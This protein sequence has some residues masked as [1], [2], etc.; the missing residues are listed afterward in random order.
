M[1]FAFITHHK[2]TARQI[3]LAAEKDIELVPVGVT[4]NFTLDAEM[5]DQLGGFDGV[6][7]HHPA[8]ALRLSLDF[9]IGV[10]ED[11]NKAGLDEQPRFE[12]K[13]LHIYDLAG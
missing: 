3:E 6:V 11:V 12:S 10:F 8:A 7:V 1:R 4:N 2:P 5:L 9:P 13:A